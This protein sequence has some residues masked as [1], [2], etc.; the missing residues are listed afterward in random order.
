MSNQRILQTIRLLELANPWWSLQWKSKCCYCA[1]TR[2]LYPR[3][4][5]QLIDW[6]VMWIFKTILYLFWSET[7]NWG[8]G[9]S[10]ACQLSSGCLNWA[11]GCFQGKIIQLVVTKLW[12]TGCVILPHQRTLIHAHEQCYMYLNHVPGMGLGGGM[13]GVYTVVT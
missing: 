2:P 5:M 7:A 9:V 6:K 13:G 3:N 11:L 10:N 4:G 8:E 1:E 12:M